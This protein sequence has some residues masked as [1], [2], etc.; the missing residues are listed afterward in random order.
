MDVETSVLIQ[1]VATAT[2]GQDISA[3][4]STPVNFQFSD[5]LADGTG[6]D[7]ADLV[8]FDDASR[9]AAGTDSIDLAGVLTDVFGSAATFVRV[10]CVMF[11]NTSTTGAAF[12]VGPGGAA[13]PFQCGLTTVLG[14]TGN[15]ARAIPQGGGFIIWAPGATGFAVGA[16]VT[17]IF[18]VTE[19]ATFAGLYEIAV[20]GAT[21]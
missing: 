2:L 14:A 15:E 6:A 5:S 13:T 7:Q 10:K 11:K 8:W 9:A 4:S 1:I 16:G 18:E 3:T 20:V 12:E 19:T 21:A 17:D